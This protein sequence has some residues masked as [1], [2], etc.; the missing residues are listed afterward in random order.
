MSEETC[1]KCG[2]KHC[3]SLEQYIEPFRRDFW[4]CRRCNAELMT[5]I[6]NGVIKS[7]V[8]VADCDDKWEI[9]YFAQHNKVFKDISR[10]SLNKTIQSLI[11]ATQTCKTYKDYFDFM[12]KLE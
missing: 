3:S 4:N 8:A 2:T 6:E 7:T 12:N 1:P 10:N 9:K 5:E 11:K